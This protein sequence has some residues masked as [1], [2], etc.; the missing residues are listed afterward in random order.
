MLGVE[1]N[2][3]AQT[4]GDNKSVVINTTM[5]LSQLKKKHNSI[6]YQRVCEAIAAKIINF[7]H[8]WSEDNYA[9]IMTKPLPVGSFYQLVKPMLFRTP[10]W[11]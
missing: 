8:I 9:D 7:F 11:A 2:G 5:P 4:F 10:M 1:V 3:P 6:A